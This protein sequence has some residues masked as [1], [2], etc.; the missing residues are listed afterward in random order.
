M[1]AR[2]VLIALILTA[3][4]SQ[5]DRRREIAAWHRCIDQSAQARAWLSDC[6]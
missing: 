2:I 4:A 1:D 3:C 6:H 5:P